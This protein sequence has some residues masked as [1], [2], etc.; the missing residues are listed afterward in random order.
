MNKNIYPNLGDF[1]SSALLRQSSGLTG[2]RDLLYMN[3]RAR[4]KYNRLRTAV[5]KDPCPWAYSG[6]DPMVLEDCRIRCGDHQHQ[7]HSRG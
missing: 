6:F 7:Y 1:T 3:D 4:T 5:E 2:A